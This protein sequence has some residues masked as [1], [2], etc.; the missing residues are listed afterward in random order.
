MEDLNKDNGSNTEVELD[1][2]FEEIKGS[3]MRNAVKK[4][5]RRSTMKIVF[6]SLLTFIV[7]I[8]AIVTIGEKIIS[9]RQFAYVEKIENNYIVQA[10]NKFPGEFFTINTFL[11]GKT[12]HKT[13]KVINGKRIY[14]GTYGEE[15]SLFGENY[16]SSTGTFLS[17]TE[18]NDEEIHYLPRYN[19]MGQKLMVFYYPYVDY[20]DYYSNDLDL[21]ED[22]GSNQYIE[23]ALSFDAAYSIDE[24][25]KMMP[26]AVKV[27]WYWVDVVRE[28]DKKTQEYYVNKQE[29]GQMVIQY[30]DLCY[31]DYAY[32]FKTTNEYGEIIEAP[33][34]RFMNALIRGEKN[35]IVDI[36]A[37]EDG[38]LTKEDIKVQGIVV[39][40][41]A[42]ALEVLK[43]LPYI[44]GSSM[45]I[46][47]DQY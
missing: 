11:S 22:V 41:E 17:D 6:I 43:T 44:K 8:I 23:M 2:M 46:V 28:E 12:E 32:G 30:P 25:I 15:Y 21:L 38:T 34:E 26:S 36:L 35:H 24:V 14:T 27:T 9:K 7:L 39:T 40:G 29:D 20:T 10:P 18:M 37:G 4:A 45:G 13:Y 3:K 42:E 16:V 1:E 47:T 31:E 33:E 5:K 19:D